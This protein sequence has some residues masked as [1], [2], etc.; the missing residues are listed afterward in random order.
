MMRLIRA[1]GK[2]VCLFFPLPF[3]GAL[4]TVWLILFLCRLLLAYVLQ[5]MGSYA[6]LLDHGGLSV[7]QAWI[8]PSTA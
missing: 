7:V 2:R 6:I 8:P 4:M 3:S 1:T 5:L